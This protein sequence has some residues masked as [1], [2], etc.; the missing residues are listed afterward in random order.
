[1]K[2]VD[3]LSLKYKLYILLGLVVVG[4]VLSASIG[5]FNIHKMKKNLDSLYF[6]SFIPLKELNQIRNE[7]NKEIIYNF[8]QLKNEEPIPAEVA[9]KIDASRKKILLK[10]NSYK[11]HFKRD[12]EVSYVEYAD[13][14]MHLSDKYLQKL[15]SVILSLDAENVSK[16]STNIFLQN[17]SHIDEIMKNIVTYESKMARYDRKALLVTYDSTI[18]TLIVVLIFILLIAIAIIS[19][20]FKSIQNTQINLISASRKLQ[21]ANKKLETVSI[22]DALTQLYNRRYFNLIYNRE[23]TRCI[24]EQKQLVFMMLDID[25]F[26]GYNDSYGHLQGDVALKTVASVMKETLKRPGDY[27]FRLGGEEFGV[28]IADIDYENAY[29]MAQKIRKSVVDLKIEHKLNKAS[30][31]LSISIGVVILSPSQSVDEQEIIKTA[32]ENLYTAKDQG[33]NRVIMTKIQEEIQ[34]QIA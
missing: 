31:F 11:S 26:K 10:W 23:L 2:L 7:Y 8:Y 5:Y 25:F 33:R 30:A 15:S 18:Y 27:L 32:D 3:A 29:N 13:E 9:E 16:L 17:I 24:R 22:T 6:G 21:S 28:L 1:L 20:V 19:M 4:L 34:S 12:Y 14:Q